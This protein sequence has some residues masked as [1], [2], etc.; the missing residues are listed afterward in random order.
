[1]AFGKN[2]H[3]EKAQTA[4]QKAADATDELSRV[5]ALREAAHLWDRAAER[6][7]PGKRRVEY[8]AHAARTR[9]L[10][11]GDGAADG[12]ETG[13]APVDPKLMN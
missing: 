12:A 11:D 6:E 7:K 5:R 10:A 1:M 4:E 8:E 3:V 13:A 2:P 9:A